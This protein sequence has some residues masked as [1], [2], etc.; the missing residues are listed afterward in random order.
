[1]NIEL[2]LQDNTEGK[3]YD[4][5]ELAKGITWTT[6]LSGQP[7]KLEFSYPSTQNMTIN[8]GSVVR[9]KVNS[10]GV[11]FGYVFTRKKGTD[12]N[13]VI[14]AYDQMR[15]LKNSD[16]YVISGM[17]ASGLFSKVCKDFN[18]QHRVVNASNYVM[19]PRVYD[20]KTMFDIIDWGITE[21]L[22]YENNWYMIRDNFGTL[23]FVNLNS[24]KTDLFI[25]DESLLTDYDFESSIDSDTYNQVK[26]VK[27][28]K[29]TQKREVY[30]VKDSSTIGRWGMLQYFETADEDLNEAQISERAT[31]LLSLKNRITKK[32]KV[33]CIGDLRVFA[34]AGVVFAT[35]EL[36]EFGNASQ[37]Q[38]YMVTSCKHT[39][40]N[41]DHT[42]SLD[43]QVSV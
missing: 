22:A 27:E 31:K 39:F 16:T 38:Y 12:D 9:L 41:S 28:N 40:S 25:G 6:E 23:E 21:T 29:T 15:Y 17:T 19:A 2:I 35:Q 4:I 32:L 13:V 30:I 11:F 14:T 5:S 18:L 24:L 3:L 37:P 7:G 1:M 33:E 36:Q 8:E 43:L 20:N 42:M 10:Q 26:I 34:G